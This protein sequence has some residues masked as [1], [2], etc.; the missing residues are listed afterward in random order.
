[1]LCRIFLQTIERRIGS[2]GSTSKTLDPPLQGLKSLY[3]RGAMG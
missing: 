3:F 1:M 2:S